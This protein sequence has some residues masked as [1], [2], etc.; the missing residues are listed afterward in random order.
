MFHPLLTP[1][2]TQTYA[3]S[4]TSGEGARVAEEERLPPGGLSL[5]QG[6]PHWYGLEG[7]LDVAADTEVP[8]FDILEYIRA[9]FN[10]ETVL[11]SIT[12]TSAANPG[13]Y[14][15]WHA[16]CAERDALAQAQAA[17]TGKSDA[18]A[19]PAKRRR[20]GEWNWQ[21]VWE[22]R[23][24]KGIAESLTEPV[25]FG[26]ANSAEEIVSESHLPGLGLPHTANLATADSVL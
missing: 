15:A 6:F 23:V 21:G 22:Q 20:P 26:S 19:T 14:H 2:T 17:G 7:S 18:Q 25:L 9:V 13:A 11:N 24:R 1:L 8:V 16:Y 3:T 10:D 5:R 4:S 12:L